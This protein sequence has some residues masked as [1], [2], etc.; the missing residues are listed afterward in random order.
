MAR[1]KLL[2]AHELNLMGSFYEQK[3]VTNF[4]KPATEKWDCNR[5][6]NPDDPSDCN[7]NGKGMPQDESL[8]EDMC[9]VINTKPH[10]KDWVIRS[11]ESFIPSTEME[12]LDDEAEALMAKHKPR[13]VMQALDSLPLTMG[14]VPQYEQKVGTPE[15]AAAVAVAV[16]NALKGD[17][18]FAQYSGTVY[19]GRATDMRP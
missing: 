13:S 17:P 15:F 14:E 8:G 12:P 6:L 5:Y 4:G 18:F 3:L 16:A 9:C 2:A 11:P 1:F 7:Y 19:K 10:R